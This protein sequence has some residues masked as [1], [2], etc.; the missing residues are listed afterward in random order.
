MSAKWS[1]LVIGHSFVKRAK[2]FVENGL[3]GTDVDLR[4]GNCNITWDGTGGLN[5]PGLLAQRLKIAQLRPQ[6]L[7]IDIG[8]VDLS[9]ET[10]NEHYL[11]EQ[12]YAFAKSMLSDY[13]VR[14]VF[15]VF[16]C[17]RS[18]DSK[19]KAKQDV[20]QCARSYNRHIQYLCSTKLEGVFSLKLPGLCADLP[21]YLHKDG[22]HL[23]PN[24]QPPKKH[25]GVF[26]YLMGI[27]HGISQGL[28]ICETISTT[29]SQSKT[30]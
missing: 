3:E 7:V 10:T 30:V 17:D 6:V 12:M 24:I 23:S 18:P 29:E 26:K 8:T 13:G 21:F 28:K 14:A 27:R 25:S 9:A 20:N 19:Y 2:A 16:I 5:F 15:I 11:A 22:L 4:L 1:A